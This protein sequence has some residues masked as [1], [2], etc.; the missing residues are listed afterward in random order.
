MSCPLSTI[1]IHYHYHYP[2]SLSTITI[3][4]HYHYPLLLGFGRPIASVVPIPALI[5]AKANTVG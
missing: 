3:H 1:T 4:Y 5:A 2:L